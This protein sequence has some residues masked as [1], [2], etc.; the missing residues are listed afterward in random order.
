VLLELGDFKLQSL[1]FGHVKYI[2]WKTCD[3]W[4]VGGLSPLVDSSNAVG[5]RN[6]LAQERRSSY[7]VAG[8][9]EC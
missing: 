6:G 4:S 8:V 1:N 9:D 2:N 3:L 5:V 7:A